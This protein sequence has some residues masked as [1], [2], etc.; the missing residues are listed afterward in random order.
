MELPLKCMGVTSV[1]LKAEFDPLGLI[2]TS[3]TPELGQILLCFTLHL[4]VTSV[5]KSFGN[6][7]IGSIVLAKQK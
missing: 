2:L 7:Q 4:G 6:P 5:E 1:C 3:L